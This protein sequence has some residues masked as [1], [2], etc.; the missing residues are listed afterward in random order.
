MKRNLRCTRRLLSVIIAFA[1][2]AA[3]ILTTLPAMNV[4]SHAAGSNYQYAVFPAPQL[5][6]TQLA[7]E[8]Y[9]HGSQNAIDIAPGGNVFAPFTGRIVYLDSSWGYAVLQSTDM[10]YYA[11]GT[12][13]YM[14]ATFMHDEDISNLYVGKIIYQGET[15]YQA[16]GM[17]NGNPNSYADHVHIAVYRGQSDG[18]S[19]GYGSGN[20]YAFDAFFIDPGMTPSRPN[21]GRMVS[22]NYMTNGAPS[23]W[24]NLWRST[25]DIQ[26]VEP[27]TITYYNAYG[28][29]WKNA[30]VTVGEYYTLS[31]DYPTKSG[32]Y[33]CGWAYE[34][35]A[36]DFEV[37]PGE[38]I[39][40]KGNINLYPVYVTHSEAISGK[41]VF[42]YKIDDFTDTNYT[43]SS[44]LRN[45]TVRID[46]S[47]WTGWTDYDID[48]VRPSNTVQVQTTTMYRYY[49]F[50]C[51]SCGAHE[52]YS[53]KCD[54]GANIPQTTCTTKWFTI[55]YSQSGYRSFSYTS[56]KY[57]TTSLGDG[58][59]WIFDSSNV[60]NTTP[61]TTDSANTAV[62]IKTGYSSRSFIERYETGTEL[63]VAYQISKKSDTYSGTCGENV[64]WNLD[65]STGVLTINGS[66]AMNDYGWVSSN[67]NPWNDRKDEIKSIVIENG[68]TNIGSAAFIYCTNLESITIP[69]SVTSIANNSIYSCEK[70]SKIYYKGNETQWNS[71]NKDE[72]WNWNTNNYTVVYLREANAVTGVSLNKTS[73]TLNVGDTL[74]LTATVSPTNA[75]N[76]SVTWTTS[77]SS[78]ARVSNGVVTAVTAGTATITVTT[79]DGNYTAKCTITVNKPAATLNSISIS[80]KP[81]K[82]TYELGEALNTS[83][84][85]LKLTYS[86]GSSKIVSDGFTVSGFNSST[87][88]TKTV[89]VSYEGKTTSF[90]V[91]VNRNNIETNAPQVVLTDAESMA[92]KEV[93]IELL[94]KNNPGIAGLAVSLK[95]D[96]NVLTLKDTVKGNLFSGFTAG[97]NFAWDES[98]DVTAD[99]VLASF[100]FV[101]ADGAAVGDYEIQVVTRSCTNEDLDDVE[102]ASVNGKVSV[103]DF[104]YGDSNGD[105]KI[106]MKD[107]VLLRKFITNYDFDTGTSSVDVGYGADAN[108]DGKI[109][110]KDVVI[111]R[112]YITNYDFDT[113]TSSVVLGPQ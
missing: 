18:R 63:Y 75:T 98:S 82:T 97:K 7:Y 87:A 14:T 15:F 112:K 79:A 47:Y 104:V 23:D 86:D 29:Q 113:G 22:G 70:L 89:T 78:V 81:T 4:I 74:T 39:I 44:V 69:T 93:T 66:G 102:L 62:V 52:P 91:T 37:R 35:N 83:G 2:M 53:G 11:D 76:K 5:Y 72:Y 100:T 46:K 26:P 109:D 85:K 24:S 108:G 90:S 30:E 17:G 21:P 61:G 96:E 54:C 103:I 92:G 77:N 84:L 43:Y 36:S 67:W 42:I 49:Y 20:V 64:R 88:G 27:T 25:D 31:S 40:P 111:L 80:S 19:G 12:L 3:P 106:D 110:M 38:T 56:A 45:R 55:P 107:V 51:P 73:A 95:Y 50:L 57:W 105:M 71:I 101:I 34:N 68:V 6:L 28:S 33:F 13:D 16:G 58:Q 8:S 1:V 10:V 9:S 99:G 94:I 48:V 59:R 32:S 65:K 60:N 41:E